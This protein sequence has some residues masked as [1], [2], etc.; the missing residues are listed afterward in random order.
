MILKNLPE[1]HEKQEKLR[2]KNTGYIQN[3]SISTKRK[4]L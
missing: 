3:W 1:P 2:E 4:S